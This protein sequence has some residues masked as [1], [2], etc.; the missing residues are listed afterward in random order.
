MIGGIELVWS[1]FARILAVVE[2]EYDWV[3]GRESIVVDSDARR[4][5][6][7]PFLPLG[8]NEE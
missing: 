6:A 1:V 5:D 7:R 4:F 2:R 3:S 8:W